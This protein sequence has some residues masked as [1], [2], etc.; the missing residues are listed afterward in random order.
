MP[1]NGLVRQTTCGNCLKPVVFAEEHWAHLFAS[2]QILP[3]LKVRREAEVVRLTFNEDR[4][5]G[6]EGTV[7]RGAPCCLQCGQVL[8]IPDGM[9]RLFFQQRVELTCQH[10]SSLTIFAPPRQN[11]TL[12]HCSLTHVAALEGGQ[13]PEGRTSMSPSEAV[14]P[15]TMACPSCGGALSFTAE[16]SRTAACGFCDAS[17][18]I[19]DG[20][21]R[22]LHPVKTAKEWNLIVQTT[23]EQLREA[24]RGA[25]VSSVLGGF[26]LLGGLLVGTGVAVVV[27]LND[28][29]MGSA[30]CPAVVFG[31]TLLAFALLLFSA[32][33]DRRQVKL[34]AARIEQSMKN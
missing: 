19:P 12:Q 32:G 10:C 25:V 21:W 23:P 26:V 28:G 3:M 8:V 15:I 16:S 14:K 5:A 24:G 33:R 18:Y 7:V 9:G 30:V 29:S 2:L 22:Q 27:T 31:G 11:P 1:T 6:F 4:T 34:L 20:L 17:V 13:V